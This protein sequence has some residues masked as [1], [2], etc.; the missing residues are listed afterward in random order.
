MKSGRKWPKILGRRPGV[1]ARM[2]MSDFERL[3]D[4]LK[5]EVLTEMAGTYFG[6]R[7]ALDSQF[8]DFDRLTDKLGILARRIVERAG[9]LHALLLGSRGAPGFYAALGLDPAAITIPL[10]K[11]PAAPARL[12]FALTARGRWMKLVR[13]TYERLQDR[14][15][16]YL[17]GRAV[18]DPT[19]PRRKIMSISLTRL[20]AMAEDINRQVAHVNNELPLSTALQYAKNLDVSGSE[21]ERMMG[22]NAGIEKDD[23]DFTPIDFDGMTLPHLPD[24]PRPDQAWPRLKPWLAEFWKSN[25]AELKGLLE[26]VRAGKPLR[27]PVGGV[28]Q[29]PGERAVERAGRRKPGKTGPASE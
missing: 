29:G 6:A 17:H 24:L 27:E 9:L 12:P 18:P 13:Q 10:D 5:M 23:P 28:G 8:E 1:I 15:D 14:T 16:E 19:E 22:A 3:A 25:E 26:L 20:R 11:G 4:S 7:T 21:R 2:P